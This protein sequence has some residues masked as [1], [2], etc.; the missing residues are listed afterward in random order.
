MAVQKIKDLMTWRVDDENDAV[1]MIEDYKARQLS[2]GYTVSKS[3]YTLKTKKKNGE[4]I[5]SW[6]IVTI[7]FNYE[8]WYE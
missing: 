1:G 3:G 4:I 7:E 5:D 8:V 2:E 6:Y